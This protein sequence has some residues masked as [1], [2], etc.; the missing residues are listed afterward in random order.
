MLAGMDSPE[1]VAAAALAE[2]T[3]TWRRAAAAISAHPDLPAALQAAG[4]L[5]EGVRALYDREA[6]PLRGRQVRRMRQASGASIRALAAEAGT[7]RSVIAELLDAA[8]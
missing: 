5:G 4:A 2:I 7:S 8:P 3:A 6:K 1:Q